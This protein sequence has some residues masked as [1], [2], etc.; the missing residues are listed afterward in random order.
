MVEL[1][2]PE[3]W[4]RG[5]GYAHGV[6]AEGR[7]IFCAGQ[8][9]WDPRTRRLVEGGFAAQ[10]AQALSNVVELLAA[11]GAGPGDVARMT[12][13]ITD[14]SAYLDAAASIGTA[15]RERFG[16]HYPAMSVVV[17]AGLLEAGALVEIEATAVLPPT[18]PSA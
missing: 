10:V 14:R 8:I 11:A 5:S 15:Y 2:E 12:W 18:S 4:G 9:G 6:V 13:Y 16:R 17:V 7:V 3:G 1:V